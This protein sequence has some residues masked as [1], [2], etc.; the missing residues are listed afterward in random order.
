MD[1]DDIEHQMVRHQFIKDEEVECVKNAKAQLTKEVA[2]GRGTHG[3]ASG[4]GLH[5]TIKALCG[6]FRCL[7]RQMR[8]VT[9]PE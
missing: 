8:F 3:L 2:M 9:Y 5:N 7:V 6:K 1:E 4:A